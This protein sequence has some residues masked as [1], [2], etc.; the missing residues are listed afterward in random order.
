[1]SH[2]TKSKLQKGCGLC[3]PHKHRRAPQ[4]HKKPLPELRLIGKFRRVRRHDLGDLPDQ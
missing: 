3:N 4:A 2:S 1:M